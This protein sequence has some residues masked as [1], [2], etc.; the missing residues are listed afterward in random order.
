MIWQQLATYDNK[1]ISLNQLLEAIA[2]QGE[3]NRTGWW[4]AYQHD[5]WF[6]V[7]WGVRHVGIPDWKNNP[8]GN[9]C[10]GGGGVELNSCKK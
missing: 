4:L 7:N 9:L 10:G 1:A 3:N 5:E 6:N 8:T 2:I